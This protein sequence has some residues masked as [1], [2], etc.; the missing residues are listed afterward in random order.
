[1]PP[2][3]IDDLT[4]AGS[5]EQWAFGDFAPW[6]PGGAYRSCWYQPRVDPDAIMGVGI[7]GQMLYVDRARGVVVAKQ[8]SWAMAD[9]TDWHDDAYLA[10][11]QI[12]REVG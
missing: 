9:D 3:Y 10:C 12:A 2:A 8:S 7:H 5:D 11:R 1:V 4:R 6:L